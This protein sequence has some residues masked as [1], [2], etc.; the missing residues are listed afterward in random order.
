[1]STVC[2]VLAAGCLVPQYQV[3]GPSPG[4]HLS[5]ALACPAVIERGLDPT[6]RSPLTLDPTT[7]HP[8]HTRTTHA[9]GSG[10]RGPH[11]HAQI[12]E[13]RE[14]RHRQAR[15]GATVTSRLPRD[16]V[17]GDGGRRMDLSARVS[18]S[19]DGKMRGGR[20]GQ[21]EGSEIEEGRG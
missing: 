14:R 15:S 20:E 19:G 2:R 1:M 6:C 18:W 7:Y 5:P 8:Q 4:Q 12:G 13:G 21:L 3:A 17:E 11:K 9:L 10:A 16:G